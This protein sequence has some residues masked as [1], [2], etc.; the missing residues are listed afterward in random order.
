[1][2]SLDR[3][4]IKIL[5]LYC[6]FF[7]KDGVDKDTVIN[8]TKNNEVLKKKKKG[9]RKKHENIFFLIK[10]LLLHPLLRG[11]AFII[12]TLYECDNFDT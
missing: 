4:T 1:M 6:A 8:S 12:V 2:K 5:K 11:K 10:L 9:K 7:N 3:R